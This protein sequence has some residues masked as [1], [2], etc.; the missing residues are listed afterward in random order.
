MK[1]IVRFALAFLAG[2]LLISLLRIDAGY[3]GISFLGVL[4]EMSVA[5]LILVALA[6]YFLLWLVIRLIRLRKIRRETQIVRREQ[7]ARMNFM[8]GILDFAAGDWAACEKSVLRNIEDAQRPVVNYLLAARAADLQGAHER[9]AQWLKM[10]QESDPREQAAILISQAEIQLRRKQFAAASETLQALEASGK[11]NSRS[12]LLLARLYRQLGEFT[13]LRELEPQ[14]RAAPEIRPTSVDEL[15]DQTYVE[16]L[17]VTAESADMERLNKAWNA[18][19]KPAARRPEVVLAYARGAMKCGDHKK[20]QEV[21][22]NYLDK[23]WNDA[24]AAAYGELQLP[25]PLEPLTK[26][27]KWLR[28]RQEDPTLLVACARLSLRAELYGKARSYLETSLSIQRQPI[29]YQLL[30]NLLDQLG[31]KERAVQVLTEGLALA[32]GHRP[33]LPKVKLRRYQTRPDPVRWN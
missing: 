6:G 18:T 7:R 25:E 26:A 13:K 17:K 30:G 1:R 12:I 4:V 5:T 33:N 28:T 22:A 21:L 8:R 20:A 31:E 11:Q 32:L 19:S 9:S 16:M 23:E 2:A 27:E 14:L 24:L 29:T 10:A 15:M 3:V